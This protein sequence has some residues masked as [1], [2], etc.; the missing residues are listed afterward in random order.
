MPRTPNR[1]QQKSWDSTNDGYASLE[2]AEWEMH[3]R[4]PAYFWDDEQ[5]HKR[6]IKWLSQRLEIETME[7]WYGVTLS[8]VMGNRGHGIL[9]YYNHSFIQML[10]TLFPKYDWKPWLFQKAPRGY[11][12]EIENCRK[13]ARWFEFES[14]IEKNEDWYRIQQS[15]LY[16]RNGYGVMDHFD[17]SVQQ[18]LK[19][20]YPDYDWIPWLFEQVPNKFWGKQENRIAYMNWLAKSLG[21]KKPEDWH[22]VTR[23]IISNNQG[24][25]LMQFGIRPID[26]VRELYPNRIWHR[27]RFQKVSEKFWA[28]KSN[29]IDYLNWLGKLLGFK[30]PD[31]WRKIRRR[32]F[33]EH[34]GIGLID[35]PYG[36]DLAKATKEL[37]PD[38]QWNAWE[39]IKTPIGFWDNPKNSRAYLTWLGI[40]MGFKSKSEWYKVRR[41]DFRE[42]M[43]NGFIKRFKTAYAGLSLAF[44]DYKWLPWLFESVP[45]GFWKSKS[46]RHWYLIWL[47]KQLKFETRPQWQQLTSNQLITL[48]GAGLLKQLTIKQ[49]RDEG[50]FVTTLK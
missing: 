1:L 45:N 30:S 36:R 48:S 47:G 4:L 5:N 24:A 38:R 44:P 29:R 13:Y 41:A 17:C 50:S 46:N 27:W 16:E 22:Q 39:F 34:E 14:G 12:A 7:D 32:D 35:G 6:Y 9:E 10:L 23:L 20:V 25:S 40:E 49:I 28:V 11:W 8:D 15:D 21:Y 31:D 42:N 19:A 37:F 43:G 26:L 3:D 2:F 33:K 18:F